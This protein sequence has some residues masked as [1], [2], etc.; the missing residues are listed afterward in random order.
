[1]YHLDHYAWL[2]SVNAWTASRYIVTL[3]PHD[4][5]RGST[6]PPTTLPLLCVLFPLA[7]VFVL[8]CARL[9]FFSCVLLVYSLALIL[10]LCLCFLLLVYSF[11][12]V[13]SCVRFC[14]CYQAEMRTQFWEVVQRLAATLPDQDPT[15]QA[16]AFPGDPLGR[17]RPLKEHVEL[18]G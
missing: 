7:L 9:L 3:D 8:S 13:G 1:M 2:E 18:R 16:D 17:R 5:Q 14:V 15:N 11:C 10:L 4:T 6:P 12:L